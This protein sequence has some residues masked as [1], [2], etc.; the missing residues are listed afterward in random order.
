MHQMGAKIDDLTQQIVSMQSQL[1]KVIE[2]KHDLQENKVQCRIEELRARQQADAAMQDQHIVNQI[3]PF[4]KGRFNELLFSPAFFSM[5]QQP[6]KVK[7]F[8]E[9]GDFAYNLFKSTKILD[10]ITL[11]LLSKSDQLA[12]F[13][14]IKL[15]QVESH[16]C[17]FFMIEITEKESIEVVIPVEAEN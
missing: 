12:E 7:S 3:E 17:Y 10:E 11:T 9:K 2:N 15:S 8:D 6:L 1:I 4:L 16:A 14:E 5:E 13:G